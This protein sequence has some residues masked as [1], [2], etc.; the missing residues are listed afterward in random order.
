[1]SDLHPSAIDQ[2]YTE[3]REHF[4]W[5]VIQKDGK[6]VGTVWLE[7]LPDEMHVVKL[8]IMIGYEQ[9]L[10]KGI[11]RKAIELATEKAKLTLD[12]NRIVLHV[13]QTNTR[14]IRC[15]LAC[16]F[17]IRKEFIKTNA[18]GEI[19]NAYRMEKQII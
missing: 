1:M 2:D 19:I 16:G 8:G 11:G 12:F 7:Q 14:A 4:V 15:Y 13:R 17:V 6:D 9:E 5:Y 3:K 10:G 18:D